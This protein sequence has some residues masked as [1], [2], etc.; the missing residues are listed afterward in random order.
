MSLPNSSKGLKLSPR[1]NFNY[2]RHWGH[3]WH[4]VWGPGLDFTQRMGGIDLYNQDSPWSQ[5]SFEY[6]SRSSP[7]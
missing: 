7:P 1:S 6:P 5:E 3:H 4:L 2:E